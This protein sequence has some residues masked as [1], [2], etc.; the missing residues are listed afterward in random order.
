MHGTTV[1]PVCDLT[2]L[3]FQPGDVKVNK[4]TGDSIFLPLFPSSPYAFM[5]ERIPPNKFYFK[6]CVHA[7]YVTS[8]FV[9]PY[10]LWPTR[11]P[12]PWDSPAKN[13]GVAA[14]PSLGD[15]H[16]PGIEPT[17][18]TSLALAG[19]FFTTSTTCEALF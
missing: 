12:C 8:D 18:L 15:L 10:G 17:S 5:M 4:I 16:D 19:G 7:C 2:W 3:F 6:H 13:T 11:L 1:I 14:F 9:R